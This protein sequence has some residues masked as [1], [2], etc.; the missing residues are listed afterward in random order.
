MPR[1]DVGM[2]NLNAIVLALSL[3]FLASILPAQGSFTDSFEAPTIDPF[4][5]ATTTSGSISLSGGGQV[6]SGSQSAR[7]DSVTTASNK[8]IYLHHQFATPLYG[9]ASVWMFDT[10]ATAGSSNYISLV[11]GTTAGS[12]GLGTWDYNLGSTNGGSYA[13]NL[14]GASG[15][16]SSI[17]RTYAWHELTI[18]STANALVLSIDGVVVHSGPGGTPV[19]GIM[20]YMG[21]PSWRPAW[22]AYFDDFSWMPQGPRGQSNSACATLTVNGVGATGSGPFLVTAP[23]GSSIDLW[24]SGPAHQ[25]LV[26]LASPSLIP[27][28]NFGAGLVVDLDLTSS[29][30]LFSGLDPFARLLFSTNAAQGTHGTAS[31]LFTV[32]PSAAG[33]VLRL[34]GVVLDAQ[35]ICST[36]GL[37]T[38]ASFEVQF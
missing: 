1:V 25:P 3:P 23:A 35:G 38:T 34:Q 27:G 14:P 16:M 17:I 10:G 18:A 24:W 13:Y 9:T 7:F 4:W 11:V 2:T 37:M 32:P 12:T 36:T 19:T 22:T 20:L 31:Q 8:Y 33:G 30:I 28:Q 6:H 5:A 21:G 29:V 26:L 15:V